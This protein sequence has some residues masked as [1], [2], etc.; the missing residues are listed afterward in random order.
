[1]ADEILF[2]QDGRVIEQGTPEMLL[3]V[4]CGSRTLDFCTHLAEF[5]SGGAA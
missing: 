2:M 4:E 3:D 1:M 5:E